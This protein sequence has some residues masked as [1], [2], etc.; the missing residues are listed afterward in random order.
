[1]VMQQIPILIVQHVMEFMCLLSTSEP[2]SYKV[3]VP[4]VTIVS[5][6][7][8]SKDPKSK[9]SIDTQTFLIACVVKQCYLL[10]PC[11]FLMVVK[12]FNEMMK[13][14]IQIRNIKGV[15][16]LTRSSQWVIFQY[17]DN[18]SSAIKYE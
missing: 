13:H 10:V 9:W 5:L 6:D 8:I 17:V 1:M 7:Q 11:L 3:K 18:T 14:K 16:I 4:F 12:V 2:I 15:I